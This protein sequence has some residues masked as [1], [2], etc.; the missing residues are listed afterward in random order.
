MGPSLGLDFLAWVCYTLDMNKVMNSKIKYGLGILAILIVGVL[1]LASTAEA[2]DR[3]GYYKGYSRE[4]V[5]TSYNPS[6]ATTYAYNPTPGT[7]TGSA[8][9][10]LGA[11][12]S[13]KTIAKKTDTT[14]YKAIKEEFSDVT[15]NAL[16][17]ADS[18]FP[19]SLI[20]WLLFAIFVLVIIVLVR[21][22]AGLEKKYNELPAK[23]S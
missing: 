1:T 19:S 15:A 3:G 14:D 21:K 11:S 17:G 6:Y 10:V 22:F 4:F 8:G 7:T 18:F 2:K 20:G 9:A 5:D 23:Y 12:T 13:P 16:F